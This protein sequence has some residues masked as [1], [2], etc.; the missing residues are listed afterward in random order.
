ME[1]GRFLVV[2]DLIVNIPDSLFTFPC[3]L[4]H[5]P[6]DLEIWQG[7]S[8]LTTLSGENQFPVDTRLVARC[9]DRTDAVEGS[10]VMTC[11][12]GVWD[13]SLPWCIKTSDRLDFDGENA[14]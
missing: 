4:L 8:L 9:K 11:M 14:V 6:P 13:N 10:Q 2:S 7:H 1:L 5:L 3:T 12:D